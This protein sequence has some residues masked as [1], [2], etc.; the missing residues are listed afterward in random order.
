MSYQL[1]PGNSHL[2]DVMLDGVRVPLIQR[3]SSAYQAR[4]E[5]AK[6][7]RVCV[8]RVRAVLRSDERCQD[9]EEVA[10]IVELLVGHVATEQRTGVAAP[11][12]LALDPL[13]HN[14]GRRARETQTRSGMK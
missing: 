6:R 8:G 12:V 7:A 1:P 4:E 5:V 11:C 9:D 13:V 2:F 3:S 10:A 14:A